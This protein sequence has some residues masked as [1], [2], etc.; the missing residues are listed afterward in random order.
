VRASNLSLNFDCNWSLLVTAT[1]QVVSTTL[2][3]YNSSG[4]TADTRTFMNVINTAHEHT[5]LSGMHYTNT[6][7]P[8]NYC[9][10]LTLT[11]QTAGAINTGN[12]ILA[13]IIV[14][15]VGAITGGNL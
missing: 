5:Q 6:L 9:A 3:V 15:E 8:G 7:P 4:S 10:R 14:T 2:T 13:S 12:Q 1:N 11:S